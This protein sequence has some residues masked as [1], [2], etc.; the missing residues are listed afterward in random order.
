[1]R[2]LLDT[3]VLVY[4]DSA[5]E[6]ERQA[7]AI[8]LI[9]LHRA[10]GTAVLATQVLQEFVNVAL[11]R[12][13]LPAQ[14]IRERLDFYSRFELV[15]TTPALIAAALDLTVLHSISFYD[16]MIVEAAAAGGCEQLLTEDMQDGRLFSGVRIV[17]PFPR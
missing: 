13:G 10:A 14:L 8:E 4:A 7:R 6:P 11:R 1:M 5:D 9:K 15:Q 16:A 2:S 3:N 12:L 17:N